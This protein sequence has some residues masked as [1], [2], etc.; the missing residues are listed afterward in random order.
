MT[1]KKQSISIA[2]NVIIRSRLDDDFSFSNGCGGEV[3][4]GGGSIVGKEGGRVIWFGSWVQSSPCQSRPTT[5]A[6]QDTS[7]QASRGSITHR[8]KPAFFFSLTNFLPENWAKVFN[9][10][11]QVFLVTTGPILLRVCRV[12]SVEVLLFWF[13][14]INE[15]NHTQCWNPIVKKTLS[16]C[17]RAEL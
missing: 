16:R 11:L 12:N 17:Y 8:Q 9:R 13:K 6:A 4:V 7:R 2:W 10:L 15:W 14:M 3:Q 1:V 5:A